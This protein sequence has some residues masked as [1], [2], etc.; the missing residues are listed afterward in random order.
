M[1]SSRN[2]KQTDYHK[3]VYKLERAIKH[4]RDNMNRR[5]WKN[6]RGSESILKLDPELR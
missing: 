3:Q 5:S 1:F 2:F 4:E 6:F